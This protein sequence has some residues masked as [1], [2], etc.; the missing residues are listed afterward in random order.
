MVSA[1]K[2]WSY[3]FPTYVSARARPPPDHA[4]GGSDFAA[5]TRR[6]QRDLTRSLQPTDIYEVRHLRGRIGADSCRTRSRRRTV[7]QALVFNPGREHTMQRR[8]QSP[9]LRVQ[10]RSIVDGTGGGISH[11]ALSNIQAG[12][13]IGRPC[14]QE[15][16]WNQGVFRET[17]SVPRQ[18]RMRMTLQHVWLR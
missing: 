6:W 16:T 11:P 3:I 4:G 8:D 14:S 17:A 12:F 10:R 18:G 7:D 9:L 15:R 1:P 5:P 13:G 2:N